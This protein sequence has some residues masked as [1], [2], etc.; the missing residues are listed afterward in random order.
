MVPSGNFM[1][2]KLNSHKKAILQQ[3]PA[4]YHE[5]LQNE[6]ETVEDYFGNKV[7]MRRSIEIKLHYDPKGFR[8]SGNRNR[9]A[10]Q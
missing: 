6:V 5:G 2:Q 3:S 7:N 8:K 1:T 4:N 9:N 10:I